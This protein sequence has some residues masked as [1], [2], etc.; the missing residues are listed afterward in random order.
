[1]P[2]AHIAHELG[3]RD[4]GAGGMSE[5]LL[6][7]GHEDRDSINFRSVQC[8]S[9]PLISMRCGLVKILLGVAAADTSLSPLA[10][11]ASSETG[12]ELLATSVV[13]RRIHSVQSETDDGQLHQLQSHS[14]GAG[15][16]QNVSAIE[17]AGDALTRGAFAAQDFL[18]PRCRFESRSF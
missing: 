16:L 18:S 6:K 9:T 5:L 10:S 1:M 12:L 15:H 17:G 7:L 13:N 4:D 14:A 2:S 3:T 8:R 11:H